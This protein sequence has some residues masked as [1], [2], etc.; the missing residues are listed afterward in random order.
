MN[1]NKRFS[2]KV[3]GRFGKQVIS[4][5]GIKILFFEIFFFKKQ[6]NDLV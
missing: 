3:L 5:Q 6:D 2:L 1:K 4:S